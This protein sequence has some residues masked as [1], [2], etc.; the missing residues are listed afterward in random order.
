LAEDLS[1]YEELAVEFVFDR[2]TRC[3]RWHAVHKLLD[4]LLYH[5]LLLGHTKSLSVYKKSEP[6]INQ[7]LAEKVEVRID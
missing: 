2:K 3:G 7:N 1:V 4:H 6:K 5:K